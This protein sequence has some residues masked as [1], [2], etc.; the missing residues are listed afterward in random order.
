MAARSLNPFK[1]AV[2][3]ISTASSTASSGAAG[4]RFMGV[5]AT[6][7]ATGLAASYLLSD[8]GVPTLA[9]AEKETEQ[10]APLFVELGG[11]GEEGEE[12]KE[13]EAAKKAAEAK[14]EEESTGPESW[15]GVQ[16]RKTLG[17]NFNQE[18][19]V[20]FKFAMGTPLAQTQT[21]QTQI[22]HELESDSPNPMAQFGAQGVPPTVPMYGLTLLNFEKT[23]S[24]LF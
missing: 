2:R 3:S 22:R 1:G 24:A 10:L 6:A 14:E 9:L 15:D 20:G 8:N 13:E 11:L 21:R 16:Q 18:A 4:K 5:A 17:L 12:E 19:F 23:V 7:V